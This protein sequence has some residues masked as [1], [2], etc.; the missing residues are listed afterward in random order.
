MKS[1]TNGY[2]VGFGQLAAV[3]LALA[4]MTLVSGCGGCGREEMPAPP[5]AP[6]S[7]APE[8]LAP[9]AVAPETARI[10]RS[11]KPPRSLIEKGETPMSLTNRAA[12]P[13]REEHLAKAR[14]AHAAAQTFARDRFDEIIESKQLDLARRT[15][16]KYSA[17]KTAREEDP[18]VSEAFRNMMEA[19]KAYYEAL[20]ENE[21][22]ST[23]LE[24]EEKAFREL[25]RLK[26]RREELQQE[27]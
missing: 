15:A 14:A 21:S 22:Y 4:A 27:S 24:T 19:R 18:E 16:D 5:P 7:A 20:R 9:D 25:E 1:K 2:R 3:C 6:E 23:A 12:M 13:T 8:G 26:E 11:G 10:E 17:E